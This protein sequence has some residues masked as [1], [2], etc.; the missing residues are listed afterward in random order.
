MPAHWTG[1]G[2]ETAE[3]YHARKTAEEYH[4]RNCATR[5]IH[6][7]RLRVNGD[8]DSRTFDSYASGSYEPSMFLSGD[9]HGTPEKGFALSG[10]AYLT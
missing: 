4:A 7:C 3:E 1:S 6:L 2:E 8:P 9:D 10:S 5:P